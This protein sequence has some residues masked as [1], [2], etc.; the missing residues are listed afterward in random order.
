MLILSR[1]YKNYEPVTLRKMNNKISQVAPKSKAHSK[2]FVEALTSSVQK[3]MDAIVYVG[4]Y[5]IFFSMILHI[6][7]DLSI[8]NPL[9]KSIAR[10]FN[11]DTLLIESLILGS[12]EFSN[13]TAYISQF[14]SNGIHYLG[15]LSALIAFGGIC[16]FFQTAQ[17]FVNTKL[18]LN[19]YLLAKTIQAIFAYSY[20]LLLFPIYE[21]YTTGIPIQINS[22]RLSLVIGLFLIVGTGLKFAEN[23]TSPVALKN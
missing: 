1:F 17:L 4:G 6:V 23:M 16:V 15:M 10:L 21:A 9:V 5:V 2:S 11:T 3:G 13:G 7:K 19:L 18:S 8:F 22:Y 20:T 14:V 12:L